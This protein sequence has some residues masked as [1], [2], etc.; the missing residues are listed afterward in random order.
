MLHVISARCDARDL[1]T[2]AHEPLERVGDSSRRREQIVK[3][4]E[5]RFLNAIIIYYYYYYFS[6]HSQSSGFACR[7]FRIKKKKKKNLLAEAL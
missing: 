1:H 2:I 4:L 7:N 5:L 6:V 3:N